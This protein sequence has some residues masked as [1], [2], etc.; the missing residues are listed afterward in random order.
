[1]TAQTVEVSKRLDDAEFE[2]KRQSSCSYVEQL[3]RADQEADK[4]WMQR[5]ADL[6]DLYEDDHWIEEMRIWHPIPERRRPGQRKVDERARE[7][8]YLW[9]EERVT[10]PVTGESA[11][12]ATVETLLDLEEVLRAA[13][14]RGEPAPDG[15]GR[16]ALRPLVPFVKNDRQ[17]E[18][19]AILRRARNLAKK[20]E[21]PGPS[22]ICQA[23]AE[24]NKALGPKEPTASKRTLDSYANRIRR[25]WDFYVRHAEPEQCKALHREL[26][27]RYKQEVQWAK[28]E[29]W[30][31]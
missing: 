15:I 24:H 18:L 3:E 11:G 28:G 30:T 23:I 26:A 31:A 4:G 16:Q 21:L 5:A 1:M 6:S 17:D 20:G 13:S 29:A 19:P 7:R 2:A 22:V 12:K 9:A 14:T 10:S 25:D 27:E 8:F